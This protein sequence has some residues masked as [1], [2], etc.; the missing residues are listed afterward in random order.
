MKLQ[1]LILQKIAELGGA[2]VDSDENTDEYADC[3]LMSTPMGSL[4]GR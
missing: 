1:Y 3:T 2:M 4:I